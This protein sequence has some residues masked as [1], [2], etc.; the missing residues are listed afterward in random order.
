[1]LTKSFNKVES[2]NKVIIESKK[3]TESSYEAKEANQN[4]RASSL[5][6]KKKEEEQIWELKKNLTDKEVREVDSSNL[7]P[8]N[9]DKNK[10]TVSDRRRVSKDEPLK[11]A[12][13]NSA[14]LS[15]NSE[16]KIVANNID[17]EE[18]GHHEDGD[19]DDIEVDE[20]I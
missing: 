16:V 6:K 8:L 19:N 14:K 15:K 11:S 9:T 3:T 12:R 7:S 2:D 1:L 5:R 4:Q 20:D 10:I 17:E 13:E 18:V